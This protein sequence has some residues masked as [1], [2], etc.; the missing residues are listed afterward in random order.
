VQQL[1]A[2]R[3]EVRV[4]ATPSALRFVS[5]EALEALTHAPV[6]SGMWAHEDGR[7][8][9]LVVPH[10]ALAAWADVVIVW[11]ATAS[12]IQRIATGA[13]NELVSAV[14]ISTRAPVLVAPSMNEAM[15]DAPSVQRNVQR[16]RGDGFVIA[17]GHGAHEVADTPGARVRMAGGAP[18]PF[19]LARSA[20]A[21]LR[22]RAARGQIPRSADEWEALHRRTPEAT[23]AWFTDAMP[24]AIARALATHAP[25]PGLLW[26]VGTGHGAIA[27][28]AAALGYTVV[29]TD[30]SGTALARARARAGDRRITFVRDDVTESGL[31]TPFDVIVDRGTLH[32]LP[33]ERRA[34]WAARMLACARPGAILLVEA[35]ASADARLASHP[36]DRAALEALL[37]PHAEVLAAEPTVFEG[38][39]T[40]AP[41]AT[42]FVLR[43]A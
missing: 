26:D 21:L 34:A 6:L 31:E 30:V 37:A 35:H 25:P 28:E 23:H 4:I 9:G 39:L 32:V 7:E 33:P 1:E 17:V 16:L 2:R 15:A 10:L 40:P 11:P 27:R 24:A 38:T 5:R 22:T 3:F 42:L 18:P 36:L 14:A 13:T 20:E 12:T 29:A 8:T 43:R 19:V 41:A